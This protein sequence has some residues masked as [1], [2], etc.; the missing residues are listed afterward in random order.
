MASKS[1]LVVGVTGYIGG[2]ILQSLSHSSTESWLRDVRVVA[3]VRKE[4]EAQ[5]LQTA[6]FETIL[7]PAYDDTERL[8]ELGESFDIVIQGGHNDPRTAVPLIQGL[9]AR[10]AKLNTPVHFLH[11]TGASNISDRPITQDYVE[12]RVLSDQESVYH[13]MKYRESIEGYGQRT[14]D[15]I[16]VETGAQCKVATYT[17]MAPTIFGIGS[18][19]FR[20]YTTQLPAMINN[21]LN[22]GVCLVLG[23]GETRWGRVHVD[24]LSM[25]FVCLCRNILEGRNVPAGE[26]GVYFTEAGSFTHRE[27]SQRLADA[28][29]K[30]GVLA[31]PAV[32]EATLDEVAKGFTNGN[33]LI[34]ELSYG[35]NALMKSEL[36]PVLGWVPKYLD[37]AW[38]ASFEIELQGFMKDC[39]ALVQMPPDYDV[40]KPARFEG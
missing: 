3:L 25:F 14:A 23:S 21:M 31:A 6:G 26:K 37:E 17:V 2:S 30:L 12:S 27:Y 5:I 4:S 38:E 29:F 34:A 19:R 22:T 39:P 24:D 1:I 16:T 40:H 13:Y 32:T 18:G 33:R 36:G 8:Q 28:G 10:R 15:I 9:G 20:R 35:A 7:C 11:I